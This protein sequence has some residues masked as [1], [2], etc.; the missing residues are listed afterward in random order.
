MSER[1]TNHS[2]LITQTLQLLSI[3]SAQFRS[4]S[5]G[6]E[7]IYSPDPIQI[8]QIFRIQSNLSPE[9]QMLLAHLCS[10]VKK[11]YPF[12][13]GGLAECLGISALNFRYFVLRLNFWPFLGSFRKVW[14]LVKWII[15]FYFTN[16]V[17][18][19]FLTI[20]KRCWTGRQAFSSVR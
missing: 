20:I 9:C 13:C 19:Y 10:I 2:F 12:I 14:K 3:T 8:Q 6:Y 1:S 18:F 5:K 15:S 11:H 7:P 16:D 4:W 17:W